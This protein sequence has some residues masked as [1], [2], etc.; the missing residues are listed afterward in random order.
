MKRDLTNRYGAVLVITLGVAVLSLLLSDTPGA[1]GAELAMMGGSL[2]AASATAGHRLR[3]RTTVFGFCLVVVVGAVLAAARVPPPAL[4]LGT[5]GVLAMAT[6]AVVAVGA[7][8]LIRD[9]GV[10]LPVVFGALAVYLLVGLA[11]SYGIGAMAAGGPGPYFSSGTDGT[12]AERVYFSF[13]TL[14]TTGYGDFTAGEPFGR[15]VAVLEMLVGQLY[16]V[17]VISLL[18]GNLRRRGEQ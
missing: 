11:F 3:S 16:L 8:R 1:R 13:S 14:T 6:I 12:Q 15:A 17:T 18:V 9:R 2:V 4:V 7:A 10:V 5:T